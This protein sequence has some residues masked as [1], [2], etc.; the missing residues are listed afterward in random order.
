M[1]KSIKKVLT[2]LAVSA[3]SAVTLMVTGCNGSANDW[4]QEKIDQLNCEHATTKLIEAV[5]PT[6]TEKGSTEGVEC[7]DCGKVITKPDTINAKGHSLIHYEELEATC[8]LS[9]LTEGEYCAV[10]DTWVK[11]RKEIKATGHKVVELKGVAPT[12]TET[13]LGVGQGCEYCGEVYVAQEV[14]PITDHKLNINGECITCDYV[15]VEE[16]ALPACGV[17][18]EFADYSEDGICDTVFSEQLNGVYRIYRQEEDV[19]LS[20]HASISFVVS[21][22]LEKDYFFECLSCSS[23]TSVIFGGK[24]ARVVST[25]EYVDIW[26]DSTC[27][28][29]CSSCGDN[30]VSG[31]ERFELSS[32]RGCEGLHLGNVNCCDGVGIIFKIG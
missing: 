26:I 30:F 6:C 24:N 17:G 18:H 14:L 32:W 22:D 20:L 16:T 31:E 8:L 23:D 27:Y 5:A 10:C 2:V 9:G 3:V 7:V 15:K 13:G 21:S 4:I 29:E 11:E 25:A 19:I 1:K 12:C 28:F